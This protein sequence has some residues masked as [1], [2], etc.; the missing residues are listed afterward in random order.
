MLEMRPAPF[1]WLK[2][3]ILRTDE[4]IRPWKEK[5]TNLSAW[6]FEWRDLTTWPAVIRRSRSGAEESACSEW[7]GYGDP[8]L[9]EVEC[10]SRPFLS[11]GGEAKAPLTYGFLRIVMV[12]SVN[13]R[14]WWSSDTWYSEKAEFRSQMF[15]WPWLNFL[16]L[17]LGRTSLADKWM[18]RS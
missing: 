18:F 9:L 17:L 13:F 1:K 6:F 4:M 3:H 15:L 16:R 12:Q 8:T 7:S 5:T 10:S 11:S 14:C 2:R